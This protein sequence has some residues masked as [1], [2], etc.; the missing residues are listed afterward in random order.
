MECSQ[1]GDLPLVRALTGIH[2]RGGLVFDVTLALP[3]FNLGE[4]VA[5][6]HNGNEFLVA[7]W[8][9]TDPELWVFMRNVD[10]TGNP[11]WRSTRPVTGGE[12]QDPYYLDMIEIAKVKRSHSGHGN[13]S[14]ET[15]ARHLGHEANQ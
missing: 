10:G 9:E 12:V 4:G 8:G 14:P 11:G 6:I 3:E 15:V 2:Y 13:A 1:P 5:F 7:P